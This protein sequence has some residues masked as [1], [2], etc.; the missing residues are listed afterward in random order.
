MSVAPDIGVPKAPPGFLWRL[1]RSP[2][3]AHWLVERLQDDPFDGRTDDTV[4]IGWRP[5][6][7]ILVAE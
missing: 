4:V 2:S 6:D 7:S 5:E 3:G 1:V